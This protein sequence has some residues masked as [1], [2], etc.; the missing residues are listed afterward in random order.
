MI[1][2]PRDIFITFIEKMDENQK[3]SLSP[4]VEMLPY[5]DL[6]E[7]AIKPLYESLVGKYANGD[8]KFSCFNCP[9]GCKPYYFEHTNSCTSCV[10]NYKESNNI[11]SS[12]H[13]M[14]CPTCFDEACGL[15]SKLLI[16]HIGVDQS[17]PP[18]TVISEEVKELGRKSVP[19]L[20]Y[21]KTCT[22]PIE[23]IEACAHLQCPCGTHFCGRCEEILPLINGTRYLHNCKVGGVGTNY[24]RALNEHELASA[25][26]GE[27]NPAKS[28]DI[29]ATRS[30]FLLRKV[31]FGKLKSDCIS[32]KYRMKQGRILVERNI[33]Q[34]FDR[35]FQIEQDFRI[36]REIEI[37]WMN[38][39]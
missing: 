16:D 33:Q 1:H 27:V 21:C 6:G 24:F 2:L 36:A 31:W 8:S 11:R 3:S 4:T 15:C 25:Q 20:L 13:V 26:Y 14:N 32:K 23:W 9:K 19:P 28:H 22:R 38:D 39:H 10:T 34:E 17:C 29:S 30:K 5:T 12:F 18:K 7:L 35:E 37:Q